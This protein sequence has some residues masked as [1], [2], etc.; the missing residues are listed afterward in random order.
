MSARAVSHVGFS[1][2]SYWNVGRFRS[3]ELA[4]GPS[5]EEGQGKRHH[6]PYV[7]L[8]SLQGGDDW[9]GLLSMSI[10]RKHYRVLITDRKKVGEFF[11]IKPTDFGL[12]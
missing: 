8:K 2:E 1:D 5:E 3:P 9:R 10:I 12:D 4:H 7:H 11:E 6:A